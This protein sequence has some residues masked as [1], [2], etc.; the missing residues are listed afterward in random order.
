MLPT[1]FST[2][3]RTFDFHAPLGSAIVVGGYVRIET[4]DER[5]ILGQVLDQQVE[6]Q[7]GPEIDLASMA[8]D[9]NVSIQGVS[10]AQAK[11]KIQRYSQR[12]N[13]VVL[14]EI[15]SATRARPGF[16]DASIAMASREDIEQFF[17]DWAGR[18]SVVPLGTIEAGGESM[19]ISIDAGG[20]N[21]HTFLCG[22]SGSGKTYSLGVVLEQ[23]LLGTDL[24][25][26]IL[27]PNADYVRLGTLREGAPANDA[28]QALRDRYRQR[29][30]SLKVFRPDEQDIEGANPLRIRFSDLSPED[31]ASTLQL[32]PLA[33]RDEFDSFWSMVRR[34]GKEQYQ[35]Q[36]VHRSAQND[37][38][39]S[40]RHVLLRI[41]NLGVADWRIWANDEQESLA[42]VL[43]TDWRSLVLDLSRFDRP[44]ERSLVALATLRHFWARREERKPV[45]LVVDE[46]HN[47]CP[48][49]PID[50][51]QQAATDLMISIA[52]EGRKYGIYLF[53]ATQ[54]PDKL[55]P[56]VIS[57][58]D[59]LMLMRMNSQADIERLAEIFSFVPRGLLGEA[60]A[61]RQGEALLAGK[62][63]PSPMTVRI[64][65]RLSAEG[66]M[67][68][69]TDWATARE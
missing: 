34:V 13:G 60:A 15:T 11:V 8:Q 10:V 36:D 56:N 21:R 62:T 45:L 19:P 64:G 6:I 58:C 69:P 55:H 22:Q 42:D 53:L 2:D 67:D 63:V 16:E 17:L 25:V 3:G 57:Q 50:S 35:L 1:A 38:S 12:G 33:N 66:G 20:F 18:H 28:E 4:H 26:A 24:R 27:D 7:E 14:S 61:F 51:I 5:V 59:N 39:E 49:E 68:I 44:V 65:G 40:T 52:G 9:E 30:E 31:Q 47:V 32:D 43:D 23:L 54:R 46:A 29:T 48:S 37:L 41:A